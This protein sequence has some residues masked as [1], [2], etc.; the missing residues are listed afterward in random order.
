MLFTFLGVTQ[1]SLM[2]FGK[3]GVYFNILLL[4][5]QL[6][7]SGA[8]IPR[9]LLSNTYQY[10]STYLPATY[11]ADGYFNLIFGGGN[12]IRDMK[13]MAAILSMALV[14]TIGKLSYSS[15]LIKASATRVV[16]L[17]NTIK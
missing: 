2:I 5:T 13:G 10:V 6:V 12:F 11:A 1:M 4:A 9:A 7:T 8:I 16:K 14:V 17:E 3:V 15:K